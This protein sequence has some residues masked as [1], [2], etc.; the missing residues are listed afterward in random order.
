MRYRAFADECRLRMAGLQLEGA[1]ITFH[2][3]MP[4][5]WPKYKRAELDGQLHRQKPDLDNLLKALMDALYGDDSHIA[6]L[7][8][9]EKRWAIEGSIEIQGETHERN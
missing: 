4:A 1:H 3:P 5:S 6:R 7:S 8:G 9:L 2:L